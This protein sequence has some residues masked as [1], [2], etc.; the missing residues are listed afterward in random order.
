VVAYREPSAT[1]YNYKNEFT[2]R[3]S[4]GHDHDHDQDRDK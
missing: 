2:P 1:R 4:G 3:D